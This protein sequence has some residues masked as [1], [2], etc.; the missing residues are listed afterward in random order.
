MNDL[1]AWPLDY[2]FITVSIR[3][4]VFGFVDTAIDSINTFHT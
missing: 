2:I 1:N 3:H 4:L